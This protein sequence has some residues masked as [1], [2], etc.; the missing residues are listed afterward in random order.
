MND[1]R[2]DSDS[3]E[4]PSTEAAASPGG[5]RQIGPYRLLQKLGEGGMGEVWLAEQTE[6]VKREVA[7]KV[8]KQGMD[9]R[10]VVARFEAERQA[11]AMMDHPAVAKVFDAGTTPEGRPYF[12]MEYVRGVPI[13]EH[14]DRHRL[15]NRERLDLFMQVCE[16]VQHAHQK[17]IIHRDLKPANVLV[18][19]RDGKRLPKI[20]DFGVAKATAQKLTEKTMFTEL[21][22]LIGTPEYMS[23]EQAELTGEDVDTRTDVYSLGVILYELLIGALPFDPKELRSG[24]YEGIRKKIRDEEPRKPS[25]RLSTLGDKSTESAKCRRVDLPGLQRQLRGDLD[26][27]TMKALEKDPSRRYG[28][29]KDFAA[30]IERH[31][32]HEPVLASPPSASY[33]ME[34]FVRRH[35]F[36]VAVGA[37][38]LVALIGFAA[39]MGIQARRIAAERDRADAE[40]D[41]AERVSTYLADMLGELDPH[42]FGVAL[43][44]ELIAQA[45]QWRRERIDS[46]NDTAA[47][48]EAFER[49]LSE[50]NPTDVTLRL[51]D[52]QILSPVGQTIE[53]DFAEDKRIAV[54]LHRKLGAIYRSLGQLDPAESHAQRALA[55][56]MSELGPRHPETLQSMYRLAS[57]YSERG[58]PAKAEALL[59][60]VVDARRRELGTDHPDTLD[61][62][63][64][65]G[66][67]NASLGNGEQAERLLL[68]VLEARRRIFGENDTSTLTTKFRLAILYGTSNRRDKAEPLYVEVLEARRRLLGEEALATLDAKTALARMYYNQGRYDEAE[69]LAREVLEVSR[70]K[71]GNEHPRTLL[72]MNNFA[73]LRSSQGHVDEA[74]KLYREALAAGKQGIGEDHPETLRSGIALR[75]L[76]VRQGRL[77]E[78]RP[79]AIELLEASRKAATAPGAGQNV[80]NSLAWELLTCQPAD[81]RDPETA[82][83]F[84]LEACEA[85]GFQN[86]A[87]LDTLALAYHLTGDTAKAVETQERALS[88]IPE[89]DARSRAEFEKRRSEYEAAIDEPE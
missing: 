84:A 16:G 56:A 89:D 54:R 50:I 5:N 57:V 68:D 4:L 60:D 88:L 79:L 11:L 47:M 62:A 51:L 74:E 45:D 46:N 15:T 73:E 38:A 39:T 78:A 85:T 30:D 77:E 64:Y 18:T 67:V 69:P 34:K 24:G 6:P 1:D 44:D 26:W 61:A 86:A 31:L 41:A 21:G 3:T 63:H 70:P 35:R 28:S 71:F 10:Q 32:K 58:Q 87:F 27:I 55:L 22:V 40:R 37:V 42:A 59:S 20:I 53:V 80:K 82:L 52:G 29:P 9:S 75:A 25:T 19:E 23:P 12:V 8:I 33:R 72:F 7:L 49:V 81:L 13:T 14:C 2:V 36:G 65:L 83:R 66:S 17:A 43:R 48:A 76:L